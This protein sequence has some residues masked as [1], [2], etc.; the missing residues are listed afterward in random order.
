[1]CK[2][3]CFPFLFPLCILRDGKA[4]GRQ[5]SS[6]SNTSHRQLTSIDKCASF[7]GRADISINQ[8]QSR[9]NLPKSFP[10]MRLYLVDVYNPAIRSHH[11]HAKILLIWV[12]TFRMNS[13]LGSQTFFHRRYGSGLAASSPLPPSPITITSSCSGASPARQLPPRHMRKSLWRDRKPACGSIAHDRT[14]LATSKTVK[15]TQMR[16]VF[17]S[18]SFLSR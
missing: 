12:M 18:L 5:G 7:I 11:P 16:Q 3:L 1:M 8:F 10:P 15:S 17:L 2:S 13:G 6:T 9:V 14:R 4:H